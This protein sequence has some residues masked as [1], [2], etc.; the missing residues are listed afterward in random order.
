MN[1]I[2]KTGHFVC[3]FGRWINGRKCCISRIKPVGFVCLKI[4]DITKP[5]SHQNLEPKLWNEKPLKTLRMLF[6]TYIVLSNMKRQCWRHSCLGSSDTQVS[7]KIQI[8]GLHGSCS[9]LCFHSFQDLCRVLSPPSQTTEEAVGI[10]WVHKKKVPSQSHCS[11]VR[12]ATKQCL[13]MPLP[14]I[15]NET[16]GWY[17]SLWDWEFW[18]SLG[19]FICRNRTKSILSEN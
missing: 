3:S 1:P 17:H 10:S 18:G 8:L 4:W 19:I 7:N 5:K 9:I 2:G 6:L 12:W 11:Y 13:N 16:P 14:N 15:G